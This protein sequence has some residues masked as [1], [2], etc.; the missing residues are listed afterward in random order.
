MNAVWMMVERALVNGHG[1]CYACQS[2]NPAL[3]VLKAYV[4]SSQ[5][6]ILVKHLKGRVNVVSKELIEIPCCLKHSAS[7]NAL[8][9]KI[10]N[11]E[12]WF[13]IGPGKKVK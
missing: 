13:I 2:L 3:F 12:G 6:K 9:I 11:R 7:L 4:S 10:L 8:G 1:V 5:Q